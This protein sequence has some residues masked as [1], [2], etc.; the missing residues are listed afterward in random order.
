M[1]DALTLQ[2]FVLGTLNYIIIMCYVSLYKEE[3]DYYQ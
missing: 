1:I 2:Y 3:S